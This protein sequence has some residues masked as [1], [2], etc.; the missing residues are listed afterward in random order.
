MKSNTCCNYCKYF[1]PGSYSTIGIGGCA[2]KNNG[3]GRTTS[4]SDVLNFAYMFDSCN[5]IKGTEI[6]NHYGFESSEHRKEWREAYHL[7]ETLRQ[8]CSE[9][10]LKNILANELTEA[11]NKEIALKVLKK[12]YNKRNGTKK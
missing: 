6:F 7:R 8:A 10:K 9:H 4:Y 11:I 12:E 3:A 1:F 5:L 2:N